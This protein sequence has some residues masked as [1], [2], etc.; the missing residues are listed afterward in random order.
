M[1]STTEKPFKVMPWLEGVRSSLR[2]QT[3]GMTPDE[4]AA[5]WTARVQ[6]GSM[7]AF[8]NRAQDV[9]S[10]REE[11][12]P[13]TEERDVLEVMP[14][15]KRARAEMDEEIKGLSPEEELAY[16]RASVA[17]GPFAELWKSIPQI[18]RSGIETSVRAS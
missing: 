7:A 5:F 9:D 10:F 11:D 4:E 18:N 2:E 13:R 6:G 8:W 12:L 17:D 16:W 1:T 15:L 3:R 14:W